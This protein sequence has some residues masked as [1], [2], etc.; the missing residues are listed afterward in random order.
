VCHRV[1]CIGGQA[2]TVSS[3][4]LPPEFDELNLGLWVCKHHPCLLSHLTSLNY[5]FDACIFGSCTKQTSALDCV[6]EL[7]LCIFLNTD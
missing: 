6:M 7:P 3:F 1:V 5:D 4:L 2:V